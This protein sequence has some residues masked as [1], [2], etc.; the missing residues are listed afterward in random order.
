MLRLAALIGLLAAPVSAQVAILEN[1]HVD[2]SFDP[3]LVYCEVTNISDTAIAEIAFKME[4]FEE[5]RTVPWESKGSERTPRRTTVQGGVEP[6]ETRKVFIW[7]S[8]ARP[9]NDA[10]VL[11]VVVTPIRFFDVNGLEISSP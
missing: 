2:K 9:E 6:S 8:D 11:R 5:G 10:A 1:C 3:A 7:T 4:V